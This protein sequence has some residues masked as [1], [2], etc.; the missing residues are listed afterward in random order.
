MAGGA[1]MAENWAKPVT[2]GIFRPIYVPN[3]QKL[4]PKC[5]PRKIFLTQSDPIFSGGY[6]FSKVDLYTY[7]NILLYH[8]PYYNESR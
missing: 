2:E 8:V 6:V 1:R 4:G 3:M 7:S 5:I